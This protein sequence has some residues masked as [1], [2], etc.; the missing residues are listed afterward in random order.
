MRMVRKVTFIHAADL[1]LDS[2][3]KG[4][5][6]IPS[7]LFEEIKNST[8]QSLQHL[9]DAAIFHHVDFVLLAGDLFDNEK[10]SLKAQIRLRRAFEQLEAYEIAVYLSYGNHDY[11]EG[12]IHQ[13]SYPANVHIFPDEQVRSFVFHKDGEALA[14]IHGFS[15]EKRA[16]I[17]NKSSDYIVSDEE[18]PFS[19]AMLHGSIQGNEDHA[20]YAPF[21]LSQLSSSHFDY[22]A[23]GHIHKRTVL[24]ENPPIVYSGNI[25]GRHR[26]E[27]GEKGCYLVQLTSSHT[28]LNFIP[29]QAITF[30]ALTIDVSHCDEVFQLEREILQEV[31]K[32]TR[33][34]P[35]L[36]DLTLTANHKDL[37]NWQLEGT[38]DEMIEILNESLAVQTPWNYL[39]KTTVHVETKGEDHETYYGEHFMA[40]LRRGFDEGV[41]MDFIQDLYQHRQARKYLEMPSKEEW[42]ESIQEAKQRMLEQMSG[43]GRS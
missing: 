41:R 14:E 20:P 11:I 37:K 2:P 1:H 31:E 9:V 12:N 19:I 27:T 32:L 7:H 3:F 16:V 36:L 38:L 30:Q 10:Q 17:E 8:F 15:Y 24:N 26:K 28:E 18:I 40:E 39:F 6:D 13:I 35:Q 34:Q 22:W 33:L 5:T 25:Q 21:Q 42:K 43:G 23:L 4:L 29:L